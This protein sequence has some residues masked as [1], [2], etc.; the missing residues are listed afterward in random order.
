MKNKNPWLVC[1]KWGALLGVA[2]SIFELVKMV[3]RNVEFEGAKMFDIAII[4]VFILLIHAGVKE[5]KE[6]YPQRLSFAKAFMACIIISFVGAVLFFGYDLLHYSL[7]EK[8]GLAKKYD[9]ALNNFRASIERDTISTLELNAYLDTVKVM[10]EEQETLVCQENTL[11]DSIRMD[12]HR[13]TQL[14]ER[15]Y[16]EKMTARRAA[17]TAHNYQMANFAPYARRV[18]VETL[19]LYIAQNEKENSTRYVEQVVQQTNSQLATVNPVDARFEQNKSHVPHYDKALTYVS[20]SAMM[21]LLYGMFFGLFV[22]MFHYRSKNPIEE[23]AE[24]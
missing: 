20:V 22:A 11:S 14:I 6:K 2:L 10:M 13:G 24:S 16:D 12:V 18:L 7:I 21:N 23:K 3:A 8:D 15:F 5:F 1:V 9:K 19:Q 4:I 17:D